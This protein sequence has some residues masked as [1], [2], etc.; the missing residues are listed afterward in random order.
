[1][2]ELFQQV[3]PEERRV[4]SE[5]MGVRD[6]DGNLLK[7]ADEY[8]TNLLKAFVTEG[9]NLD[10]D[11]AEKLGGQPSYGRASFKLDLLRALT[12][13]HPIQQA[14]IDAR[15]RGGFG[16]FEPKF[17]RAR[18][19]NRAEE[20]EREIGSP[21]VYLQRMVAQYREGTHSRGVTRVSN[22]A[23][24]TEAAMLTLVMVC[25]DL[26]AAVGVKLA[27][28]AAWV[29]GLAVSPLKPKVKRQMDALAGNKAYIDALGRAVEQVTATYAS[30]SLKE[31]TTAEVNESLPLG[32][33]LDV[34]FQ[35]QDQRQ[36]EESA[37]ALA[38]AVALRAGAGEKVTAK[39][40]NEIVDRI[41]DIVSAMPID[42]DKLAARA[43]AATQYLDAPSVTSD[44][45]LAAHYARLYPLMP[46]LTSKRTRED[47]GARALMSANTFISSMGDGLPKLF[48]DVG[49]NAIFKAI[50]QRINE[51]ALHVGPPPPGTPLE[52]ISLFEAAA[53]MALVSGLTDWPA[54]P[55]WH[56]AGL[57]P[58]NVE[59]IRN[60]KRLV[61]NLARTSV[62]ELNVS[63]SGKLFE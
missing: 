12:G 1:M 42:P 33:E 24:Y 57:L 36:L 51:Y 26:Q 30:P 58:G 28:G 43:A 60:L 44:A 11:V 3:T 35:G 29:V 27:L 46:D 56:D 45:E 41:I 2:P 13:P 18:S 8:A 52:H 54:E 39:A 6:A 10:K 20:E 53:N 49:S 47:R 14:W 7:T 15:R 50:V 4:F 32:A 37:D 22:A 17:Y 63:A 5:L 19:K 25:R 23:L 31:R 48:G 62:D 16:L 34:F 40:V 55:Q 38:E 61:A 21:G 59:P 9:G